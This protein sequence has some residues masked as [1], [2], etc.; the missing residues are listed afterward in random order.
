MTSAKGTRCPPSKKMDAYRYT[1]A[2]AKKK[3][4]PTRYV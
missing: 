2:A 1:K 4:K 3:P